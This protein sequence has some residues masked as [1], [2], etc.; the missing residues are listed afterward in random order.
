MKTNWQSLLDSIAE[1]TY[2][3]KCLHEMKD[4]HYS[5][6]KTITDLNEIEM[7]EDIEWCECWSKEGMKLRDLCEKYNEQIN[8]GIFYLDS[9]DQ[10][11]W[12][13]QD[14]AH[15]LSCAIINNF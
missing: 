11:I 4:D 15:Q 9:F 3:F 14:F 12:E 7:K 1:F 5:S 13:L 10:M 8:V 6:K 2:Q